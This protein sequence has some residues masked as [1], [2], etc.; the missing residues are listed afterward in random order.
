MAWWIWIAAGLGLL[1][2]E[3]LTPGGLFFLFFGAGAIVVGLLAGF[4]L[5]AMWLQLLLFSG[6]SILSLLLFRRPLLERIRAK[7][8]TGHAVDSIAGEVVTLT[9]DLAPSAIGKVELRG[10]VWNVQSAATRPMQKGQRARVQR[11]DGLKLIVVP[12]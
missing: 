10:T 9:E 5:D 4:G 6:S 2:M 1:L 7:E 11:V 8:R 3:L 12:E